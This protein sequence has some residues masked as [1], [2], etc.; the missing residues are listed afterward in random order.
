M[1]L[2][3]DNE[4]VCKNQFIIVHK[5]VDALQEE[6]TQVNCDVGQCLDHCE[7]ANH[8]LSRKLFAGLNDI[9]TKFSELTIDDMFVK[10]L[11]REVESTQSNL[12][13]FKNVYTSFHEKA[14]APLLGNV[15]TNNLCVN[16]LVKDVMSMK[17]DVQSLTQK[18]HKMSQTLSL[19][20]KGTDSGFPKLKPDVSSPQMK[21]LG[22]DDSC[23]EG[24]H[25][26]FQRWGS[27]GTDGTDASQNI[28]QTI[29]TL[30]E[31]ISNLENRMTHIETQCRQSAARTENISD[32]VC[33]SACVRVANGLSM[34]IRN[35]NTLYN[36]LLSKGLLTDKVSGDLITNFQDGRQVV[37]PLFS[38]PSTGPKGKNGIISF[39]SPVD[40]HSRGNSMSASKTI[41][42]LRVDETLSE[43]NDMG[44]N[45]KVYEE[46]LKLIPVFN[47]EDTSKF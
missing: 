8:D 14:F 39:A 24:E 11:Q 43:T 20:E 45:K 5:R 25:P 36:A 26:G 15:D 18:V 30:R 34:N 6:F 7:N 37:G 13:E 35:V 31:S 21:M 33:C 10:T 22:F 12:E 47:G 17:G 27:F 1:F 2:T 32:D 9:D 28:T 3:P 16:E 40:V 23:Q 42:N 38:T 44:V 29:D 46:Q 19:L 4:N 41:G